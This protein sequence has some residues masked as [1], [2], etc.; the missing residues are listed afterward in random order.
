MICGTI[1]RTLGNKA[2]KDTKIKFCKVMATPVLTYGSETWTMTRNDKRRVRTSEMKFLKK[3][4]GCTLRAV[5]YT[6][7]DV[8]KRQA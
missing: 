6:H 4:K 3:T 1:Q 2:S 8:Y 7:L 5:S